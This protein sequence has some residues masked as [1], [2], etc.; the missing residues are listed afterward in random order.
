MNLYALPLKNPSTEP[1]APSEFL[2]SARRLP[3]EAVRDFLAENPGYLA[4]EIQLEPAKA[5]A[6]AAGRA[7]FPALLVDEK[8]LP[9]VPQ[10]LAAAKVSPREGGFEAVLPAASVFV[11][12]DSVRVLCAWGW[13]A[14]TVPDTTEALTQSLTARLAALAGLKPP[15]QPSPVKDTFFRADIITDAPEVSRIVLRPEALDFSPLGRARS[16]S[17]LDNFRP[18]LDALSAP[19]FAAVKGPF[20]PAFLASRPLAGLKA[21]SE[22]AADSGLSRLILLSRSGK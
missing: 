20:L 18:L 9:A 12:Y 6:E 22:E 8:D 10:P 15:P 13:D 1:L 21:A 16:Y 19:A 17:C 7:G 2:C 3:A 14:A 4:R 5:L 11:P